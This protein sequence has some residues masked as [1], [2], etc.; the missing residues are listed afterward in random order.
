MT[1]IIPET[2]NRKDWP[3]L[4]ARAINDLNRRNT[5]AEAIQNAATGWGVY[6]NGAGAQALTASTKVDLVNDKASVIE[7]QLPSDITT[8]YDGTKILGRNGDGISVRI[9]LTFTPSD[10]TASYLWVALDIGDGS[11]IEIFPKRFE[12]TGGSGV[13]HEI[14]YDFPG[15]NLG[16]W[17]ANGATVR[18]EADGPGNV[19]NVAYIIHRLHKA[20]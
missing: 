19:E 17:E 7:S 11:P 14:P 9:D 5:E 16:T 15:Y 3:R 12:I 4:V 20:R 10:G 2:Y 18:V 6:T 8:F 13:A 1:R